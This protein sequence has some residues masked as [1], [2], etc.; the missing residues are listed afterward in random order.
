MVTISAV[1]GTGGGGILAMAEII[2]ADMVPLRERG[3]YTG[4]LGGVRRLTTAY[5]H[6]L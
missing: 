5:L 1:Q 6:R 4:I 2:V 3:K